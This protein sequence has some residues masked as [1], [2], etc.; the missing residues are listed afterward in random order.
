MSFLSAFKSV[1][2]AAEAAVRIAAPVVSIVNPVI[3]SL[4][5]H[6]TSAAVSAEAAVTGPGSGAQK[7]ALVLQQTQAAVDLIN[8]ILASQGRP[9]LPEDTVQ[10][11]TSTTKGVVDGLKAVAAATV[12]SSAAAA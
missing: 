8:E 1:L 3:G 9:T 11:V 10:V 2:H 12:S 6:A 4:L 7:A 5:L